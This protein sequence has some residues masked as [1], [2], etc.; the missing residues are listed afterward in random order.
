MNKS[1]QQFDIAIAVLLLIVRLV[2]FVATHRLVLFR[3]DVVVV[4]VIVVVVVF[5]VVV[6]VVVVRLAPRT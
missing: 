3:T 6:V 1:L 5:V 4:V 2:R